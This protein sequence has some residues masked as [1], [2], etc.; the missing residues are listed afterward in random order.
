L[1]INLTVGDKEAVDADFGVDMDDKQVKQKVKSFNVDFPSVKNVIF[2]PAD[3]NIRKEN[4][5]NNLSAEFAKFDIKSY[6]DTT[7]FKFPDVEI[8]AD[9][10]TSVINTLKAKAGASGKVITILSMNYEA[11]KAFYNEVLTLK[12]QGFKFYTYSQ[13]LVKESDR[14]KKEL[15]LKQKK[16]EEE[17][18]KSEKKQPPKKQEPKK[19]IDKKDVKKKPQDTKKKETVTKKPVKKN[20]KKK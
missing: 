11:F 12:K 18:K 14:Q 7:F 4:I 1:L 10:V 17:K 6:P 9:K 19:H 8:S 15:L 16:E 5:L 3:A 2:S 20:E 13:Y